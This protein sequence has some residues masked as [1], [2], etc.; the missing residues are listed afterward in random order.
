MGTLLRILV[1]VLAT[2]LLQ[3]W[4]EGKLAARRKR[5]IIEEHERTIAYYK[6]QYDKNPTPENKDLYDRSYYLDDIFA[7]NRYLD[8]L[9]E[10]D[11]LKICENCHLPMPKEY[12]LCEVCGHRHITHS[13]CV[14]YTDEDRS[15]AYWKIAQELTEFRKAHGIDSS[16]EEDKEEKG[17]KKHFLSHNHKQEKQRAKY[18]KIRCPKCSATSNIVEERH[19]VQIRR[20]RNNHTFTYN[21]G[22]EF[23]VKHPQ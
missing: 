8:F 22:S 18:Q 13:Y 3:K 17:K 15:K 5:K 1:I 11:N 6:A 21:Y 2:S 14:D 4:I 7:A 19:G 12:C 20:C 23:I 10:N 16:I 9:K